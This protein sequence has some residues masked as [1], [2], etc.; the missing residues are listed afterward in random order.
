MRDQ[1]RIFSENVVE[2]GKNIQKQFLAIPLE[3]LKAAGID[4]SEKLDIIA[5]EDGTIIISKTDETRSPEKSS[6]IFYR[7]GT[8]K[9]DLGSPREAIDE[10]TKAIKLKP[11]FA[12]AF[13]RRGVAKANLGNA[14][15]ALEDYDKAIELNAT[16]AEAYVGRASAKY[17]LGN[18][19]G[20]LLDCNKAIEINPRYIEAQDIK[21]ALKNAFPDSKDAAAFYIRGL[22]DYFF[23]RPKLA[24]SNYNKALKINPRFAEAYVGRGLVKDYF[25]DYKN[26]IDDFSKALALNPEYAEAYYNRGNARYNLGKWAEAIVDWEKAIALRSSY[27]DILAAFIEDAKK[28]LTSRAVDTTIQIRK[29]IEK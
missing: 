8:T 18:I 14:G 4:A 12:E 1:T 22:V 3:A 7:K 15:G 19:E 10:Y 16:L 20:A 29:E 17:M 13:Y 28:S 23:S 21:I 2:D 11:D 24:L 9:Y 5:S 26:A 25:D 27:R 6:Q